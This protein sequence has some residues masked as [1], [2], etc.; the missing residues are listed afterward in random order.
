[1][2]TKTA[3][4]ETAEQTGD[5]RD[6]PLLDMSDAGVKKMIKAAKTRGFVT[7]DE[8]NKVLP[9][10]EFSSEQIEDT[11]AMLSEMGINVI[12]N[13]DAEGDQ[14]DAKSGDG[15]SDNSDDDDDDES[16]SGTAVTKTE[17]TTTTT[18]LGASRTRCAPPSSTS[19]SR[20]SKVCPS[21]Y[22]PLTSAA[23]T[24]AT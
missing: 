1:M 10:E 19:A 11:M 16:S 6:S 20:S 18:T 14:D 2:A 9:S 22:A 4:T 7:Y 5:E 24:A 21:S 23:A 12:E 15:A 8:L 13:E 17:T 3:D